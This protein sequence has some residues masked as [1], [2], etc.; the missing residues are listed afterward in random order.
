[1]KN[2]NASTDI[3]ETKCWD[4]QVI[5][6]P[7]QV[8]ATCFSFATISAFRKA[9]KEVL[10]FATTSKVYNKK[11]PA[12]LLAKFK[13]IMSVMLAANQINQAK[14]SSPLQL[15]LTEFADKRLYARPHAT[16]PEWEYLP[17][18]LTTKEYRNPYRVFKKFFKYQPVEQ[19]REDIALVLDYALAGYNES[20]A[21]NLLQLYFHLTRLMEAAHIID[22][23]EVTHLGGHLKLGL[24]GVAE[25]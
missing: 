17:K 3:F 4:Y 19:W 11:A 5:N 12:A 1:M 15:T 16:C 25:S 7:Y 6:D 2:K 22:V 24:Q 20:C 14:K 21:L 13:V 9:I 8:F 23:R 18:M 10:L